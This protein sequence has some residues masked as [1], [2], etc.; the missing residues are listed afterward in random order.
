MFAGTLLNEMHYLAE[1]V[2][3]YVTGSK[4]K[5]GEPKCRVAGGCIDCW[6]TADCTVFLLLRQT[7]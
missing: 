5:P 6:N 3:L 1:Y 4:Q 2:D 7:R